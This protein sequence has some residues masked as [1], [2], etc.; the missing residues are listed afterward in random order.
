MCTF[1]VLSASVGKGWTDAK[2]E[3]LGNQGRQ[4]AAMRCG[5]TSFRNPYRGGKLKG[6]L[7]PSRLPF[8]ISAGIVRPAVKDCPAG[9]ISAAGSPAYYLP[10]YIFS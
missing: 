3:Y 4:A 1:A 10:L 9:R 2:A 5:G 8:R 6:S 7:D